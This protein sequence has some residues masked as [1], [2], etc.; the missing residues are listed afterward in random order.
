MN[1]NGKVSNPIVSV[2]IPS[3]NSAHFLLKAVESIFNQTFQDFEVIVVDDGS[4]DNTREVVIPLM[5]HDR[6]RYV[7]QE[8]QGLAAT[9]NTGLSVAKGEFVAFLDADDVFLPQKLVVQVKWLQEN[10]EFGLVGG[11]FY[12]MNEKGALS[13]AQR[14]WLRNPNLTIKDLLFDCPFMVPAVLVRKE[15]VD[16]V[17]GFDT[18]LRRVEDWDLWMRLAYAGCKMG[19]VE[20]IVCAYRIFSGQMTRN[21]AA[22]KEVTVSVMNRFFDQSGLPDS[23][24]QL[25]SDVLTRVYVVCAG[26]EYGAMQCGDA[27]ESISCAI[28]LTPELLTSRQTELINELLSWAHNPFVGDPL[29]YTRRVFDN[30]PPEA[31]SIRSKKHW[32]LGEIGLRVLYQGYREKDWPQ[33]KQAGS[34]VA[35]NAP[36]R[37]LNRG[38]L[39][40]LWQSLKN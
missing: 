1:Q 30:L 14:S 4:T 15:W 10:P 19:W 25:K 22:Q 36:H 23:I 13:E 7:Y 18:R 6:F 3:Y 8:N 16:R 38:V 32:A 12:Y 9:R 11:G 26:R 28:K 31:A 20:E 37:L 17:G 2:I 40:I 35:T 24:L 39:S 21:A 33:I 5:E 29:D 34:T 27:Q